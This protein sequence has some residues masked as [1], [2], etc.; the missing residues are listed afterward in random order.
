MATESTEAGKEF[1][2]AIILTNPGI[3]CFSPPRLKVAMMV[4]RVRSL[5]PLD[6]H[7]GLILCHLR[8]RIS[9]RDIAKI[10]VV[11]HLFL[12]PFTRFYPKF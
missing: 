11:P 3:I 8:P 1:E 2:A 12:F 5:G 4:K 10:D 9:D 7:F 6:K